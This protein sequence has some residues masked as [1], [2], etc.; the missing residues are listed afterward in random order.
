MN[1]L[2]NL[3]PAVTSPQVRLHAH[4]VLLRVQSLSEDQA[5]RSDCSLAVAA[6]QPSAPAL[7]RT[8]ASGILT[9]TRS[10]AAVSGNLEARK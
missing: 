9:S 5:L 2:R 10:I 1:E 4:A 6:L 8:N 7:R 3:M